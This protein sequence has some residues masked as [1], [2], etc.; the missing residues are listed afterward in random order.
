MKEKL[1]NWKKRFA[2]VTEEAMRLLDAEEPDLEQIVALNKEASKLKAQIEAAENTLA[3]EEQAK[4][5]RETA[6][7]K[8]AEEREAQIAKMV[9][10]RV[11]KALA[12]TAIKS[13]RPNY[14]AGDGDDGFRVPEHIAR[15]AVTSRFDRL[16]DL[17]LAQ[18][19][20]LKSRAARAGATSPPSERF[21]R[22]LMERAARFM[23]AEDDVPYIDDYG[24][25]KS[26][27]MP[28]FDPRVIVPF[29]DS[30][31]GDTY[32]VEGIGNV[33]H[34]DNVTPDGIKKLVKLGIKTDELVYSTQTGFGDEWVPTLMGALLWRKI[35]MEARVLP[36]FDQFDMP[37]QP[38][39]YP[40][41]GADPTVYG[42][43]ETTDQSQ[44]DLSASPI[45]SSKI[46]TD[47]VV[48]SAGKIGALSMWSEEMN[49]DSIIRPQ[50]QF[51]DQ[52][53]LA[54]AHAIDQIIIHGDETTGTTNISYYG[55]SISTDSALLKVD[56][57]RHAPL[58]D[59]TTD[60]TA[61]GVLTW[62]DVN[63]IRKLMGTAGLFGAD[64]SDLFILCDTATG[65]TFEDLDEVRTIDKYGA[66]AVIL[67]GMLGS[68][69]G[70]PIVQSQDY[71]LTDSSGYINST[72]GDNTYG[73]FLI[74][75]R[76][77]WK[78]GWRRRPRM[79]VG[80]VP[81]S[82]AWYILALARLDIRPFDTGMAGLSY[83]ISV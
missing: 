31:A 33:R 67:R 20:Y 80:Q 21:Y 28:A 2:E 5:E 25:I 56:G 14:A 81:Y 12:E 44:M 69:K 18:R 60:A 26:E 38:Y 19:Y 70:I 40:K 78:V 73:Q 4:V 54:M 17:D 66:N 30:E 27:R 72:A 71:G 58:V 57:L 8:E 7:K 53:G 11:E 68:I 49:E 75:N 59:T 48:F 23:Q 35:R 61:G 9:D 65:L 50:P 16:G 42:V 79:Y 15:L 34:D 22:A 32:F 63:T 6:T 83:A 55:S 52:F 82:D 41:E 74:V 43:S 47:K 77:G 29:S 64:P 1:S 24:Q 10:E 13:D 51:R 39:E 3:N 45:P 36:L 46:A 62:G 76:L 37:S